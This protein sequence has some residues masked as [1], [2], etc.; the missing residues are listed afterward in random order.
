[1]T[2]R[3]VLSPEELNRY[4]RQLVIPEIGRAGQ[5]RLKNAGVLIVGAGGLG[6][7]IAMYLAAAG[8]GRLGLVDSDVV[9]R[10]NLQR[11]LLHSAA[12]LGRPKT[13]SARD[14]IRRIN[15]HVH[16]DAFQMRFLPDNAP[17]ILK[18][19]GIVVDGADN[20]ATRFAINRAA[21]ALARPYVFG[22]VFRLE[23]QVSVFDARRGPCYECL[24]PAAPTSDL[25]PDAATAGVLGVLPG[26]I[27]LIE[28]TET[29]KLI[30]GIGEPLVGRLLVLDAL[31]M[32]VRELKVRKDPACTACGRR[33][34]PK[35]LRPGTRADG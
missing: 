28:A 32:N 17:R 9:E 21:V 23:G 30:L 27:G 16:V 8:V 18:P 5:A 6:S 1:M 11:Q 20:F 29:L 24:V 33:A 4:A 13:D 12:D 34:H 35:R 19:Y 15:P 10:S 26:I 25:V 31:A 7:A 3:P 22:S 14:A 2:A